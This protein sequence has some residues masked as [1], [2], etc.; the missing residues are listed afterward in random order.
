MAFLSDENLLD[1]FEIVEERAEKALKKIHALYKDIMGSDDTDENEPEY[2]DSDTK[3]EIPPKSEIAETYVPILKRKPKGVPSGKKRLCHK[4]KGI[5]HPV[6]VR[7]KQKQ[8]RPAENCWSHFQ[9]GFSFPESGYQTLVEHGHHVPKDGKI[10]MQKT[11]GKVEN[12]EHHCPL[13][14]TIPEPFQMT[15]REIEQSGAKELAKQKLKEKWNKSVENELRKKIH[16]RPV[17]GHVHLPLYQKIVETYE[18]RRMER[19]QKISQRLKDLIKPFNLTQKREHEFPRSKS[20]PD[21]SPSKTTTPK[22]KAKP[23]PRNILSSDVSKSLKQKEEER[24]LR[25]AE[26]AEELLKSSSVPFSEKKQLKRSSSMGNLNQESVNSTRKLGTFKNKPA[27]GLSR[28]E[29]KQIYEQWNNSVASVNQRQTS[30]NITVENSLSKAKDF[31]SSQALPFY[32]LPV[33]MTNSAMLREKQNRTV[34]NERKTSEEQKC[35][36]ET[37]RIENEKH[38]KKI[39]GP[40]LREADPT[41]DMK[42]QIEEQLKMFRE[43]RLLRQQEYQKELEEMMLRVQKQPLLVERQSQVRKNASK[44]QSDLNA[45]ISDDDDDD[46]RSNSSEAPSEGSSKNSSN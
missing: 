17:P 20:M 8:L 15:L 2:T 1:E 14:V 7:E 9:N 10:T 46:A 31:L 33:K 44:S 16:A 28:V 40:K 27:K 5:V 34:L 13:K 6:V 37:K 21:L 18:Q 36:E 32:D 24:K 29:Q 39:L 11:D 26:R 3:D 42:K 43:S 45:E 25:I 22:F 23:V 19:K 4:C 12:E 30:K 35:D 41:L 38:L